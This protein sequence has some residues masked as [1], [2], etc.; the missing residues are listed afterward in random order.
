MASHRVI[1]KAHIRILE[2]GKTQVFEIGDEIDPSESE[3]QAFGDKFQPIDG[4]RQEREID[5]SAPKISSEAGT[6]P[7][8]EQT[9]DTV[10]ARPKR[11][12][13]GSEG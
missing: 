11:G 2:D 8:I 4:G 1:N 5:S 3:M 6:K 12:Q 13:P 10:T 7:D 9:P